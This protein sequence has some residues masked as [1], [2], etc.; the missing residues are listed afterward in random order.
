M[1]ALAN[2]GG[3]VLLMGVGDD[4]TLPRILEPDKVVNRLAGLGRILS[5][6][7]EIDVFQL[8]KSIAI[9]FAR[10]HPCPPCFHEGRIY[11]RVGSSSEPCTNRDQL[12]KILSSRTPPTRSRPKSNTSE[13]PRDSKDERRLKFWQGLL[14][15]AEARTK[16][17]SGVV[18]TGRDNAAAKSG[19]RGLSYIYV[20]NQHDSRSELY[21][22]RENADINKKIFDDLESHKDEIDRA[23]GG[24]PSWERLD[25]KASRIAYRL[26]LGG[27]RDDEE[28]W[29]QIHEAM[30]D[31][32]IK[33]E[34]AVGPFVDNLR[35]SF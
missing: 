6:S 14:T 19:L 15:L 13:G 17:H 8:S 18:P 3:G 34:R 31:A 11:H 29:A 4:G 23:F 25:K 33:L 1:A 26:A 2:S 24:E 28:K 10:I 21:I 32:M 16:L 5:V 7:P 12:N 22:N 30:I 9:V 35:R 27:Y 20:V